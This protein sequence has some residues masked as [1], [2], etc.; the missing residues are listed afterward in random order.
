MRREAGSRRPGPAAGI[1]ATVLFALKSQEH[2]PP[3]YPGSEPCFST[4]YVRAK[5]ALHEGSWFYGAL[6]H[7]LGAN[8]QADGDS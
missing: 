7:V 2:P 6:L 5:F 4:W 8:L 3:L 1:L